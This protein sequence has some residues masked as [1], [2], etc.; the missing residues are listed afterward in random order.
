MT[1]KQILKYFGGQAEAA[2]QLR[3]RQSTISAWRKS[4]P[5]WREDQVEAFTGGKLKA[6]RRA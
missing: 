5:L 4:L 6:R 3:I 1:Y 2:R